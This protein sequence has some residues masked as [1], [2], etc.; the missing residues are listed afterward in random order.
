[1]SFV[2]S[3]KYRHVFGTASKNTYN[4]IKVTRSSAESTFCAVNP[5]FVAI[6]VQGAGGGPFL[7]LP[8]DKTGRIPTDQPFVNGHTQQVIELAWS[9]F[10]DNLLASTSEDGTILVWE[11]PDEGVKQTLTDPWQ[12]LGG[13]DGHH[14]RVSLIQWHPVADHILASGGYDNRVLVWNVLTAEVVFEVTYGDIPTC[15]AWNFNG[16]LLATT[17]KD[18]ALRIHDV[19]ADTLKA[20]KKMLFSGAKAAKCTFVK[21]DKLFCVG[22]GRMSKRM[23]ALYDL[24]NLDQPLVEEEVDQ[25]SGTV[26]PYYDQDTGVVFTVGKGDSQIRYYEIDDAE[27]YVHFLSSYGSSNSQRGFG[28]MPKRGLEFKCCEIA[29]FYKLTEDKCEPVAMTVPRK[30]ELFQPD[31]YPPCLS[32]EPALTAEEWIAGKNANPNTVDARLLFD[33]Q[34]GSA[35]AK[36][37][38]KSVAKALPTKKSSATGGASAALSLPAGVDLDE[39]CDDVKKLKA[40]VRKLNRRVLTLEKQLG[41]VVAVDMND[42]EE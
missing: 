37:A 16:S 20:E 40:T 18:K 10:N 23:Y 2:R 28:Y 13:A 1:M 27:P 12:K 31:I 24:N 4:G 32:D 6:V 11:I 3:S 25:A 26:Y 21:G 15:M 35:P 39:L 22:F 19:R 14:K 38:V 8:L 7:V 17:C 5:K 29:R 9:P 33:Q 41:D 30:S 34:K 42:E 36:K